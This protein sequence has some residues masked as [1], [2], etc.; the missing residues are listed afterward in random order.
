[1]TLSLRGAYLVFCFIQN[2]PFYT[3]QNVLVLIPRLKI[4]DYC[5][6]FIATMIFKESQTYYKA[7]E[8]ELNRHI[9][10]DF[11][12]YLPIKNDDSPDWE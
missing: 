8:N 2:E 11:S 6:K 4:S 7:L 3:S 9:K 1:M 5:K 12:I 10:R